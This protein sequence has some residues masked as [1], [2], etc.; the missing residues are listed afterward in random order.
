VRAACD[1]EFIVK[2]EGL[3]K[4][5]GSYAHRKSGNISEMVL[6]RDVIRTGH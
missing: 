2:G 1:F 5:T 4:V 3:L 6:D